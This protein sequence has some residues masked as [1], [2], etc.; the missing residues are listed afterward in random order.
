MTKTPS[1]PTG[2]LLDIVGNLRD[3]WRLIRDPDIPLWVKGVPLATLAYVLWPIDLLADAV[4]GLGQLD[5]LAVI[6]LGLRLFV[7]LAD[8]QR[9]RSQQTKGEAQGTDVIDTSYR[10]LEGDEESDRTPS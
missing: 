1:K 6:L 4:P 7:A 9:D 5:D 10:V 8:Q 2:K 3:T